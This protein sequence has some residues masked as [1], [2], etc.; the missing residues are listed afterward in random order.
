[1]QRSW[2]SSILSK[3]SAS[4]CRFQKV[5]TVMGF[6]S[7][8]IVLRI[9][10][11]IAS[12]QRVPTWTL[13]SIGAWPQIVDDMGLFQHRYPQN[14][15]LYQSLSSVVHSR[16]L[17]NDHFVAIARFQM[18]PMVS[19]LSAIP[20]CQE[21]Q[22]ELWE[23]KQPPPSSRRSCRFQRDRKIRTGR[24]CTQVPSS[25]KNWLEMVGEC[26]GRLIWIHS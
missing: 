9:V 10:Q 23:R 18:Y 12:F 8:I 4:L 21:H 17:T 14:P 13:G 7:G 26:K 20:C 19:I 3:L 5:R 24:V 2:G 6:A 16:I 25:S 1:M 11:S 22:K 15:M